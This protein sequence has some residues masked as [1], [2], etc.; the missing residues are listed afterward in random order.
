MPIHPILCR[1]RLPSFIRAWGTTVFNFCPPC[2][3]GDQL[4]V[5][6]YLMNLIATRQNAIGGDH[7]IAQGNFCRLLPFFLVFCIC[8]LPTGP[9]AA[10]HFTD[11]VLS[12][13]PIGTSAHPC[14]RN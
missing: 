3:L 5:A 11:L 7:V 12:L 9:H 13:Y 6:C 4:V 2:L 1:V 10:E 8:A 14:R